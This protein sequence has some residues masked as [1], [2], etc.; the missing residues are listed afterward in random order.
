MKTVDVQ[1]GPADKIRREFSP[2][3]KENTTT[4][5]VCGILNMK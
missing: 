5:Q 2:S 3:C 4:Y 1:T